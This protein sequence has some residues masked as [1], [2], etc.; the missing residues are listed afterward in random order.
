MNSY[1]KGRWP[2]ASEEFS[3][4]QVIYSPWLGGQV[5]EVVHKNQTFYRIMAIE[6]SNDISTRER[7][8]YDRKH[9]FL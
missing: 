8:E 7:V 9:F 6:L 4:V 1:I 5:K 3:E 2:W